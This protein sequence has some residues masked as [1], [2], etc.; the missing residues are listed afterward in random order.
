MDSNSKVTGFFALALFSLGLS[1]CATAATQ[2]ATAPPPTKQDATP[3]CDMK[4]RD[5]VIDVGTN[6]SCKLP[7]LSKNG[8]Q[9]HGNTVLWRAAVPLKNV[10]VYSFDYRIFPNLSC[11]GDQPT[12]QS[13]ELDQTAPVN[14]LFHYH[15]ALC[16]KGG[17]NCT[18]VTDPGIIII[19]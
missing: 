9:G 8:N 16:D 18:E 19:P 13:G 1:S 11:N 10:M 3:C 2:T 7:L 15:V 14:Q 4:P 5:H 17:T 12:C 6:V